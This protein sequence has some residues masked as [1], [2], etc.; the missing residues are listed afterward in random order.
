MAPSL[1][2]VAKVDAVRLTRPTST[3][4]RKSRRGSFPV[5]FTEEN[6]SRSRAENG[7]EEVD[8][9]RRRQ[10]RRDSASAHPHD[11]DVPSWDEIRGEAF[12]SAHS[13][14]KRYAVEYGHGGEKPPAEG[15]PLPTTEGKKTTD[16]QPTD[17]Q[18]G[19]T[20]AQVQTTMMND[21]LTAPTRIP[22]QQAENAPP[23]ASLDTAGAD[24]LGGGNANASMFNGHSQ[25][26][27]RV[28]SSS[29]SPFHRA[30][31]W[32]TGSKNAA[33]VSAHR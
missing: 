3:T 9:R 23:P 32:K 13:R 4:R 1:P 6:R 29:Q 12:S 14:G 8:D 16:A 19:T 24:G 31:N 20:S 21:Q 28:A 5:V 11:H 15:K 33:R 7:K 2:N 22:K 17:K 30:S 25:P 27:V 10:R 26:N 18:E